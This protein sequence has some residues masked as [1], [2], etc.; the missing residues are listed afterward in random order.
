MNKKLLACLL[1][2]VL[3]S[4]D[5]ADPVKHAHGDKIHTHAFPQAGLAHKHGALP[6]GRSIK[7]KAITSS[8]IKT[9]SAKFLDFYFGMKWASVKPFFGTSKYLP[10][11]YSGSGCGSGKDSK[12]KFIDYQCAY[13]VYGNTEYSGKYK[14]L[15]ELSR[16]MDD[17]LKYTYLFFDQ[18]RELY[19]IRICST[20]FSTNKELNI[21]KKNQNKVLNELSTRFNKTKYN[22]QQWVENFPLGKFQTKCFSISDKQKNNIFKKYKEKQGALYKSNQNNFLK[23]KL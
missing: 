3:P 16:M 12:F 23:N 9:T 14:R 5:A 2:F 13:E 22:H 8:S 19:E 21:H 10:S 15:D 4:A 18:F 11:K 7:E 17:S 6:S 1:I 20:L